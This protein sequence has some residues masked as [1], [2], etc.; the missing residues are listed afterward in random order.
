[1]EGFCIFG[2]QS[3]DKILKIAIIREGKSPADSRV[4][5]NPVQ[6][7]TLIDEGINLVVQSSQVRC[8]KDEDYREEGVPVVEDIHDYDIMLGVKEVPIDQL[9]NNK[10]YFFFSHT[11]KEQVYNRPLLQAIIE[12]NIRLIDYETITNDHGARV[13]AFGKFAGMVGAHNGLWTYG[14]RTEAFQLPRM[15][16]Q[17][18]YA[19]AKE[20]YKNISWPNVKICLTGT[21]RVAGGASMVLE[22]MGIKKVGPIEYVTKDFDHAVYTQLNSFYYAKRKDGKV[23]DQV[24]DFYDN[25]ATYDSDFHHFLPMTDIMIN[26]IYWDNDAPPFFTLSQMQENTF[27]IKVIADVTCDIAPVSSI[28]STLRASTIAN[29]VFGFDPKTGEEMESFQS[30]G[31]DMMTIDNLPNELPR[32]ASTA[33]GQMFINEV[34]PELKKTESEMMK[35]ATVAENKGLGRDFG[36]LKGYLEGN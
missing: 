11:I 24:Q 4:P 5:L 26:G 32:D 21:G 19:A 7:K 12:K 22:D 28:P 18:D 29:P 16:D 6:C 36:Y 15:K 23:F 27:K 10:T 30:N 2:T 33:F 35:R 17:Y 1:M 8:F 9:I 3:N 34:I 31:I 13:I 14:Q 20:V 25:P